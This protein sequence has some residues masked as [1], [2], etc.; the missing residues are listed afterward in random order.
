[1]VIEPKICIEYTSDATSIKVTDNTGVFDA[2]NDTGYGTPNEERSNL[3]SVLLVYYQPYDDDKFL[4]IDPT[5]LARYDANYLNDEKSVWNIPYSKD[6]WHEFILVLVPESITPLE[7]RIIYSVSDDDL[8]QYNSDL[9]LVEVYDLS[10]LDNEAIY[11][12][13]KEQQLAL[14]ILKTFSNQ[15]TKDYLIESACGNC[16]Y[17]QE[18]KESLE[19]KEAIQSSINYFKIS[20]FEAQKTIELLTKKYKLK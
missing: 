9:N 7:G 19:L 3:A 12:I 17:G 8:R 10:E 13:A 16:E 2:N 6:G 20:P 11:P 14:P 5:D 15:K 1:M 4:I 18:F